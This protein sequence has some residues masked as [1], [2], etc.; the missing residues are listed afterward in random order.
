[1]KK[2][3]IALAAVAATGAAF[4]Q[5]S[6]TLYGRVD[7]SVGSTKNTV[8]GVSTTSQFNGS[9]GGLT[10]S[11]WG[12][13]GSE[14]L[15]GGLKA[16]FQLENRFNVDD[17][18]TAGGFL[19]DARVGLT[20]AFGQ[21]HL[22]RTYT[23]FDAVKAVSVSKSVFDS[24]F[25]PMPT[26]GANLAIS[27]YDVRGANQIKYVSP[28]VA[29]FS[30]IASVGLKETNAAGA[31]NISS[32]A[33]LYSAGPLGAAVGIH[34]NASGDNVMFSG[35]YDL[36]V[37]ALSAGY[38]KFDG[39]NNGNDQDGFTVGV[40]VPMGAAAVS[41]GYSSGETETNAGA[42]VSKYTGFGLGATYALSKRTK[43]YAG[44]KDDKIKN[45]ANVK[46]TGTRL[47]AVGIRHDF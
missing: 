44:Y 26:T 12:M 35:S 40:E 11:R 2:T 24:A 23:A 1:M 13:K 4:A 3:L 25:T 10:G 5:S 41:L 39:A 6:V 27:N 17:G 38:A 32:L 33:A 8:T 20:G 43:L 47:Y 21:V 45:A 14:D 36:G 34:K 31:K 29:G 16:E 22:G 37:A 28:T 7:A 46:T 15:G 18:T 9:E 19:G 30:A 42:K